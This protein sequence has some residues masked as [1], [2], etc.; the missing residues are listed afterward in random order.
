MTFWVDVARTAI[1][2]N[3]LLL[4][5]L[6][7]VWGRNYLEFRSKHT[8]GLFLFA[9]FLLLENALALYF[10]V[11]EPTLRVWVTS[12]PVIAQTAMTTLRVFESLG[13]LVLAW[14]TWD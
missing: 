13:L 14:V 7:Y 8:L 10:Y 11:F 5:S 1:V 6:G 3:L 4:V 12:V 9:L 2:A